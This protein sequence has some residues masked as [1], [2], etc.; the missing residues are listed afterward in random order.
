MANIDSRLKHMDEIGTGVQV[1]YP[2]VFLRAWTQDPTVE[3][4]LC[5]SYNRWLADIWK[6]GKGR[7]RWAVLGSLPE[8]VVRESRRPILD[9]RRRHT[10]RGGRTDRVS[11]WP[12]L[13]CGMAYE[14]QHDRWCVRR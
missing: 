3:V 9:V 1:L 11:A 7:L 14:R 12:A 6:Q 4:A 5:R 10:H 13:R 2:T 8:Q